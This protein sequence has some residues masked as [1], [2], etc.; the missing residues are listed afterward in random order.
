MPQRSAWRPLLEE[1]CLFISV[2]LRAD[3]HHAAL[4][5]HDGLDE[6]PELLLGNPP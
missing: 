2:K 4:H 6:V 1:Q 3:R 5:I